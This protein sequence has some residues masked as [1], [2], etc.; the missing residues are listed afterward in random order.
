MPQYNRQIDSLSIH[1]S[2]DRNP[3]PFHFHMHIHTTC[4]IYI[5]LKGSAQYAVEGTRY[6]LSPGDLLLM[7]PGESHMV[8]LLSHD[9]PYERMSLNFPPELI[10]S[11]PIFN[12]LLAPFF[13][14]PLGV[15]NRYRLSDFPGNFIRYCLESIDSLAADP[16]P[17]L[18]LILP[19]V[20]ALLSRIVPVFAGRPT[21]QDSPA[22]EISSRLVQYVNEHLTD[23][24]SLEQISEQ[25]FMSQSQ[26]SRIFKNATGSSLWHYILIKR[27]LRA[28]ELLMN[29]TPPAKAAAD[30]GFRDYSAFY[31]SYRARFGVSPKEEYRLLT[32]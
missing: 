16:S 13:D 25:F 22:S 29:G 18:S 4:E 20:L 8:V 23:E 7:R 12:E 14:R 6:P 21:P 30:C 3:N 28:R 11:L 17:S 1:H 31:K 24:L 27:L 9:I 5:F 2:F 15:M 19:N 32:D 10:R 26:I